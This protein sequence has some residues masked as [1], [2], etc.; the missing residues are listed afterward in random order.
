MDAYG[1][2]ACTGRLPS[3]ACVSFPGSVRM[4]SHGHCGVHGPAHATAFQI[5]ACM[6]AHIWPR[7]HAWGSW[8]LNATA[9]TMCI[10]AHIHLNTVACTGQLPPECHCSCHVHSCTMAVRQLYHAHG[11]CPMNALVAMCILVHPCT[12]TFANRGVHGAYAP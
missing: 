1:H 6:D 4:D 9:V 11:S 2:C 8:P 12:L 7:W 10:H 5:A 3:G